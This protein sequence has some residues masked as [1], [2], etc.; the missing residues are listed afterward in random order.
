AVFRFFIEKSIYRQEFASIGLNIGEE[1]FHAYLFGTDGFSVLQDIGSAFSNSATGEFDPSKLQARID[2]MINSNEPE[3]NEQWADSKK[4]Y[5][6]Q[7]L[8]EKHIDLIKT[9]VYVTK[10]QALNDYHFQNDLFKVEYDFYPYS[11]IS[12]SKIK[13]SERDLQDFFAANQS[14]YITNYSVRK[15]DVVNFSVLATNSDITEIESGLNKL[16]NQFRDTDNDSTFVM[17]Y[18]DKPLYIPQIAYKPDEHSSSRPGF[19][20]PAELEET[21]KS[22][23]VG[24]VIGPYH[25]DGVIKIAK[26]I[27]VREVAMTSRHLLIGAQ[28]EDLQAVEKAQ[29]TTDSIMQFINKDNFAE[30][31]LQYS[32]D[33][34]SKEKGGEYSDFLDGDMVHEF[35]DYSLNEPIGKIAYVQTDFGFHIIEVLNRKK[36]FFPNLAIIEKNIEPSGKTIEKQLSNAK[37]LIKKIESSIGNS[38]DLEFKINAFKTA[39]K[40]EGLE[41]DPIFLMESN[42]SLQGMKFE[43]SEDQILEFV[44]GEKAKVGDL[45]LSPIRNENGFSVLM[46]TNRSENGTSKYRDFK[47]KIQEDYIQHQQGV[48]IIE[49]TKSKNNK[50]TEVVNFKGVEIGNNF[51]PSLIGIMSR[52]TAGEKIENV[53]GA[54]GIY[55]FTVLEKSMD[56]NKVDLSK[57]QIRL[58]FRELGE[59]NYHVEK[60][61]IDKAN[62]INNLNLFRYG[63]HP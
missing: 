15:V 52:A 28:R 63:I 38:D 35:N 55:T 8:K 45:L 25:Q 27:G 14:D 11:D 48:Q 41:S 29:K 43:S 44:F 16:K 40:N 6:E 47:D 22:S 20:Y 1:E 5:I 34:G 37:K 18:S 19:T 51:D 61:L 13:Y 58:Q 62:A 23:K 24:D 7:R 53:R 56:A 54:D 3:V 60:A 42:P 46:I 50:L 57:R 31:V 36:V 32:D 21:I 26:I 49:R 17:S 9:G 39:V 10:L 12:K 59:V 2:D 30:L 33:P 4:F